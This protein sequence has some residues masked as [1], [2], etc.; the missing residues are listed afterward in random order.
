MALPQ[1]TSSLPFP[2]LSERLILRG[3]GPQDLEA[4]LAHRGHP[5]VSRYTAPPLNREQAAAHIQAMTHPHSLE[6]GQWC[7]LAITRKGHDHVM[8]E[9]AFRF[10]SRDHLRVEVGYRLHPGYYRKGYASEACLALMEF[11]FNHLEIHKLV[12]YCTVKNKASLGLLEK[13]GFQ[14][15]GTLRSHMQLGKVF[16]DFYLYGYL[17]S[18]WPLSGH[19]ESESGST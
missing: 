8:G 2:I 10:E 19:A 13:L 1:D 9:T 16:H 15:E 14:R 4:T 12:A 11:L 7:C 3:L 18:H 6:N 17:R 5:E